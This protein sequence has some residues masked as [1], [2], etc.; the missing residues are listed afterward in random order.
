MRKTFIILLCCIAVLL[1]SYSAYRGYGVWRQNHLLGMAENFLAKSDGRNVM[2]CLGQTLK[3]NPNNL[4]ACRLMAD[5]LERAQSPAALLWRSKV[6]EYAPK[7]TDDR[8]ALAQT[9]LAMSDYTTATNA[10]QGVSAAGKNTAAFQNLAGAI[11]VAG[12]QIDQAEKYFLEAARLEPQNP[13]PRLNISVLRLQSTN[14]QELAEARSFLRA[15]SSNPTNGF[16]RCKALRELV[17]DAARHKQTDTALDLS[18]NLLHETNSAFSDRLLRLDLLMLTTNSQFTSNLEQYQREAATN[19]ASV[20]QLAGWQLSK[21]GPP[22]ALHWLQTLP[23]NVQT[24]GSVALLEAQCYDLAGN[25]PGL[26]AWLQKQNWGD[27]EFARHAFISRA[28]R[29][30]D[31][32]DSAKAEWEQ[33]LKAGKDQKPSL[34]MLL[35]FAAQW[36]MNGEGE[37]ILRIFVNRYPAEQWAFKALEQ[38]LYLNGRTRELMTLCGQEAK[39]NPADLDTKNNLASIALLLNVQDVKPHVLAA[40]VYEKA[41]TNAS[42]ASTY[43]FSLYLQKKNN[44]A[45][46]VIQ[47]LDPKALEKPSI[48]GYYGLILKAAGSDAKATT[49]FQYAFKS[50]LL[51]EERKLFETPRP[52]A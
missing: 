43:A 27:M 14:K 40:E 6:V 34:A 45:L 35:R 24:N 25:W 31:L 33:A 29:Q 28:L 15:L 12:Q 2:L 39:R 51:P 44:E 1:T 21:Q 49:Y 17:M 41:P 20:Y 11:A 23:T 42:F 16:L 38:Y 10:L 7:S 19:P 5:L 50:P 3:S 4:K 52:G 48:A 37:D 36:H 18:S 30:Q 22:K 26:Q 9:A 13:V 46:Q 47:K 8:L 32:T